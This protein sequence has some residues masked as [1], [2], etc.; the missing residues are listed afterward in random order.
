MKADEIDWDQVHL[1]NFESKAFWHIH[2]L[3]KAKDLIETARLLEPGIAKTWE[4]L[5]A[6]SQDQKVPLIA[7]HYIAPYF[8]L[9]AFAIEN[10]LKARI[11]IIKNR[12]LKDAFKHSRKFPK[13]QKN[14]NLVDLAHLAKLEFGSDEEELLRRLTRSAIWHGRYPIPLEYTKMSGAELFS[15]GNEYLVSWNSSS[16]VAR[17]RSYLNDLPQRLG[18]INNQDNHNT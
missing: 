13:I 10:I 18:L 6:H 3:Y 7:N 8:M 12:E 14:H 15:D 4:N 1:S 5:H 16:D 2:W 17:I 11:V 9:M